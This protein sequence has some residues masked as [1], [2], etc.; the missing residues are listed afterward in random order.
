MKNKQSKIS[1]DRMAGYIFFEECGGYYEL[2]GDELLRIPVI[3]VL[4]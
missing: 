3:H 2:K 4:W 1:G